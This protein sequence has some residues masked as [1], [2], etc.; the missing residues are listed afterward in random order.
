LRLS[1]VEILLLIVI[2]IIVIPPER[3]PEVMRTVGRILRELRLAS[4]TF[5]R[6]LSGVVE[7]QPDSRE[8][9]QNNPLISPWSDAGGK[10][11]RAETETPARPSAQS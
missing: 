11:A 4:N 9:P 3:L 10:D 7:D 2:A 6:E 8:S 5:M 1:I